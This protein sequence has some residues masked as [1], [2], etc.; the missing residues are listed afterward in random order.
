MIITITGPWKKTTKADLVIQL[1]TIA[2]TVNTYKTTLGIDTSV[3][4]KIT[5]AD[6]MEQFIAHA[7][8]LL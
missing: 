1:H 3:V 4:D 7:R 6:V 8:S 5:K 2:V